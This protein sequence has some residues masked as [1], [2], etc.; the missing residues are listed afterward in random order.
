MGALHGLESHRVDGADDS[1]RGDDECELAID[2]PGQAGHE[3]SR[4]EDGNQDQ[5]DA[6]NRARELLHGLHGRVVGLH[7]LFDMLGDRFDDDDRIVHHDGDRE[8]HREE[9]DEIDAEA[10]R[11]HGGEGADDRHRHRR[12]RHQHSPEVLEKEDDDDQHQA[13]C[14]KQRPVDLVHRLID[15]HRGVEGDVVLHVLG[16]GL[17]EL[18]HLAFDGLGDIERIG[19]GKLEHGNAGS[20]LPVEL[21]DLGIG[22]CAKLD[23][24]DIADT[25][26]G[27][28][29]LIAAD[30]DDVLELFGRRV[31]PL[32]IDGELKLLSRRRR[33]H[34][35]LPGGDVL[36]LALDRVD[37]VRWRQGALLHQARVEPDAHAVLTGTENR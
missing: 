15:E 20:R 13:A 22:L 31:G 10:H 24:P 26:Q 12:D 36:A 5:R 32:Q 3:G 11:S 14:L 4:Q 2:L 21:E 29:R 18:R 37:H 35:D 19:F 23:P 8:N 1:R 7:P 27:A 33:R 9:R 25:G 30:Q 16:K 34:A 28:A 6:D 17:G